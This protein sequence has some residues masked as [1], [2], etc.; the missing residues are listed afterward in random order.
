MKNL[1]I[2]ILGI[3]A[4]LLLSSYYVVFN[5]LQPFD[6]Y[7][8]HPFWFGIS[9][10]VVKVIMVF[11]ILGVIGIILFSSV[12]FD[13][14]KTGV[15]KNNLFI[16]LLVFLISS[17]VWPFATYYNYSIMSIC[18]V[19][20]TS[21]CSLLLLAGT[22]QNTAAKWNHVLGALLICIVTVLCDGVL[23]NSNYIYNYVSEN[24]HL[25]IPKWIR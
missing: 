8:N 23:W 20:V 3:F 9:P 18:S 21:I 17:I 7:V 19:H 11:Q 25:K 6:S 5:V 2:I 22:I 13:N 12:I 14:P 24:K 4:L 15:L 16:V 10:S 1:Y